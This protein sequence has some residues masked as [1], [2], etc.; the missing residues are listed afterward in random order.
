MGL[1]R[2][3][4]LFLPERLKKI[5]GN[6]DLE[7]SV[8]LTQAK[9]LIDESIQ[10]LVCTVSEEETSKLNHTSFDQTI[11]DAIKKADAD[12][13]WHKATEV[14]DQQNGIPQVIGEQFSHHAEGGKWHEGEFI[15]NMDNP[16]H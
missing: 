8:R 14:A 7:Q 16:H 4:H 11:D 5:T 13:D 2:I 1:T 10:A 15:E 3:P 9:T 12:V 6:N